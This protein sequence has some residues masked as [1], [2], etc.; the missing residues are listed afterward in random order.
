MSAENCMNLMFSKHSAVADHDLIIPAEESGTTMLVEL[1]PLG[2]LLMDTE[3][4]DK[5]SS[6][7]FAELPALFTCPSF[8]WTCLNAFLNAC[9]KQTREH[10]SYLSS[11]VHDCLLYAATNTRDDSWLHDIVE[12]PPT[13]GSSYPNGS[14]MDIDSSLVQ[15]HEEQNYLQLLKVLATLN[16]EYYMYEVITVDGWTEV[17]DACLGI[18]V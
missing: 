10:L 16:P 7:P 14:L 6:Q 17:E 9:P 13:P 12:A 8:Y 2:D 15:I 18:Q 1:K 5:N 4:E 3:E 11:K